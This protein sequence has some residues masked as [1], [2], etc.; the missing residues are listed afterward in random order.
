M[1]PERTPENVEPRPSDDPA[2][3]AARLPAGRY[4]L[5]MT[6]SHPLDL[7]V[8]E[9]LLRRGDFAWAGLIGSASK[10]ARFERQLRAAGIAADRLARLV[11][12]IG[13]EGIEGKAPAVIAASVA[14]Q[15][16][17]A[18]E[19]TAMRAARPVPSPARMA[20]P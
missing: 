17:L 13:I 14:A 1:L 2:A 11:C 4:H 16:L 19:A 9:A 12:P 20:V 15:L 6:H 7:A 5:V 3:L 8:C 10:R 18:F